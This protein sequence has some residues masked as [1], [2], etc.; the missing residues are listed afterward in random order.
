MLSR[1]HA[2]WEETLRPHLALLRGIEA[3]LTQAEGRGEVI[4]PAKERILRALEVPL[5][6]VKVLIVGQDPYP[7]PGHAV[8]LAFS[9]APTTQPLP[10]SLKNIFTELAADCCCAPPANGDLSR[11]ADQGVLL[12]NRSLTVLEGS[13]GSHSG[14]GWRS[15][16]DSIVEAIAER[17][18]PLVSILWGSHAQELLPLLNGTQTITS[19]HPSPLSAYRGFFG[20][21]PFSRCNELL[22][23]Q[24]ASPI[25][26]C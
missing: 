14:L 7:T 16:T 24:S 13:P 9:V 26:W 6:S 25:E 3:Q 4:A 11:W 22:K 10:K 20:S 8:G 23:T 18:R 19:A 2:S 17:D 12:L 1:V 15:I 5:D 21:R